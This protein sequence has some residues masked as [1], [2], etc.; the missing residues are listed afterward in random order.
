MKPAV[1]SALEGSNWPPKAKLEEL[2]SLTVRMAGKV[3]VGAT[4]STVTA[5]VYSVKP[6]SLSMIRARTVGV[7]G[8]SSNEQLIDAAVPLEA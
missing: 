2:P 8:P 6:P 4:L 3:A 7:L 1:V 5:V